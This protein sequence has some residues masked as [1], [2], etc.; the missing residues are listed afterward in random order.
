MIFELVLLVADIKCLSLRCELAGW[1]EKHILP[2]VRQTVIHLT[3]TG[4]LTQQE[5]IYYANNCRSRSTT[6]V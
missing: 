3:I 2:T 5:L 4:F 6:Q 1:T